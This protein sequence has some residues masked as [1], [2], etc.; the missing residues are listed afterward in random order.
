MI[1]RPNNWETVQ[2]FTERKTLPLGAYICKIKKAVLQSSIYGDQL[3]VLFDVA[4]GEYKGYY[5]SDF[6]ANTAQ[7][8]K[9]RGVLRLWL[10][11]DDGSD[12]D[13]ITKRTLKGFVTA[14]EK[15][16]PGYVWN[17]DENTLAGRTIGV[18][19]R[20]EEWAYNGKTGWVV[21]PFRAISADTVRRNEFT[22]PNDKPL[23]KPAATSAY[24]VPSYNAPTQ[25][26]TPSTPYGSDAFVPLANDDD[27]PF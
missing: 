6:K 14:V 2:E 12:K 20:N 15:S 22:L 11:T 8:K 1:T 17:W 23:A 27:V 24:N 10:P 4:E 9:W 13:E 26:S 7:E 21:R 16:N 19:M 3:C 18:L 5:D 25:P